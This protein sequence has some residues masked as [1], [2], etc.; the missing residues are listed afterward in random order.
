MDGPIYAQDD[1]AEALQIL[2]AEAESLYGFCR[3]LTS[4]G[5]H[6]PDQHTLGNPLPPSPPSPPPPLPPLSHLT[7]FGE[8]TQTDDMYPPYVGYGGYKNVGGFFRLTDSNRLLTDLTD[9][10][11]FKPIL[12]DFNRF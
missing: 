11:R 6:G 10:N 9:F 7:F 3:R 4:K 8:V 1:S 2:V 5:R 12:T